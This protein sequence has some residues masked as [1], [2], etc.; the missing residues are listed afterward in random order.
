MKIRKAT[1]EDEDAIWTLFYE[2]VHSVN[3]R[4]YSSEQIE[5]W[6]PENPSWS[7]RDALRK[8]ISYVVE[9]KG[10]LL[11]F[12]DRTVQGFLEGLYVHK[13]YQGKGIA[14][15]LLEKMEEEAKLLGLKEIATEGSIT[16]RPFFEAK[17][18]TC[19]QKQKKNLRGVS[20]INY[21][22]KKTL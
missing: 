17:G 18:F 16:A 12:A 7:W 21:I 5:A 3:S 2:T 10:K 14:T 20:F 8:N 11:G 4:D 15:L 1:R 6:A 19:V 13:N 22:M 9:E